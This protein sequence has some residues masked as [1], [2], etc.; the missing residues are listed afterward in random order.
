MEY[1]FDA[2]IGAWVVWTSRA[3]EHALARE[4][5]PFGITVRQ[6]QVVAALVDRG[7]LHQT[8]LAGCLGVEP[9]TLHGILNRMERQGWIERVP[10]ADDRR[11]KW[12][13]PTELVEREWTWM[14]DAARRVR[15]QAATGIDEDELET[16]RDLLERVRTNLEHG[17]GTCTE[18]GRGRE[19]SRA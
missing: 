19:E 11:C 17:G 6:W 8:D 14:A 18:H 9:P 1:D 13:V 3:L 2:S 4:L 12:V 16:L 10:D 15:A 5:S 7:R